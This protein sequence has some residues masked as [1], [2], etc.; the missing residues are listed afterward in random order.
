[1]SIVTKP[2]NDIQVHFKH[3][4]PIV[5]LLFFITIHSFFMNGYSHVSRNLTVGLY[6]DAIESRIDSSLFKN[7]LYVQALKEKE[8]RLS[9]LDDLAPSIFSK[10]DLETVSLV[11]WF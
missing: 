8:T 9:L 7:S 5:L 10:M 4:Y 11:Q 2:F 1:M 3:N 6:V